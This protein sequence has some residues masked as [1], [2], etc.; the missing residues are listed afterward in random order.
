MKPAIAICLTLTAAPV[1][2]QDRAAFEAR[3]MEACQQSGNEAADCAC[4][5]Q[6][7]SADLPDEDL[8]LALAAVEMSFLEQMPDMNL[9]NQVMPMIMGLTDYTLRCASGEF[10]ATGESDREEI[11]QTGDATEEALLLQRLTLGQATLEEMMRYDQLVMDRR[12]AE[13]EA[14]VAAQQAKDARAAEMREALRAQYD[15]EF[16][17]LHSRSIPEWPIAEFE[18]LFTLYCQ[19]GGNSDAACACGWD[20]VTDLAISYALPYLA[21]RSEGD[22]VL[23]HIS[24]ADLYGTYPAL[25]LLSER[26]AV[27][28]AL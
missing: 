3:F 23:E 6:N 26:R 2:A 19:M 28:D 25:S 24:Q 14:E 9:I 22:D 21:S 7:W 16:A 20:Q 11:A 5:G 27:C 17:R 18:T 4:I 12:A 10:A 1:F 8:P 13:R 15:A